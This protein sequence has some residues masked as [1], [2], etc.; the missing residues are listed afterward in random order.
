LGARSKNAAG[1]ILPVRRVFMY[2]RLASLVA[3]AS[4]ILSTAMY[5]DDLKHQKKE[6]QEA[7]E[8]ADKA[9]AKADRE[10]AKY[11]EKSYREYLKEQRKADKEWSKLDAK[12]RE[13]YYKWLKKRKYKD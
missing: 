13:D 5:A 2:K 7:Q 8:K 3:G 9:Q 10:A 1:V 4:L 6:A 12:E 11:D